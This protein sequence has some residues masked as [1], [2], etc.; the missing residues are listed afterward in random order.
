MDYFKN[1]RLQTNIQPGFL[2]WSDVNKVRQFAFQFTI[3]SEE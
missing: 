3:Y 2:F 1:P